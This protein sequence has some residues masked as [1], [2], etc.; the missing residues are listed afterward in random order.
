MRVVD[1]EQLGPA[2]MVMTENEGRKGWLT[3]SIVLLALNETRHN[4]SP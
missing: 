2:F 3:C 1:V 4:G